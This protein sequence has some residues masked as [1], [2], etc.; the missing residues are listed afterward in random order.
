MKK[1]VFAGILCFLVSLSFGQKKAVSAARNEIKG[2]PPNIAEARVIIK[3]ALSNPET[4]KDAETWYVAGLIENKQVDVEN[5]LEI[6]GKQ[7]NEEVMYNALEKIIPYFLKA[8]ELDQQPDAKGK[9]KPRFLKDIRSIIRA[10]RLFYINAG[11]FAYNKG[12][13]QKA[14]EHFKHFT[15]IPK[16]ELFKEEKWEIAPGDT[17]VLQIKCYS[18]MAASRIPDSKAAIAAY[19]GIINDGYTEN[20][21]FPEPE[22]FQYLS[23]EYIQIGDS[24]AYKKL[25]DQ[26]FVKF[27]GDDFFISSLINYYI[28]SGN[29]QEAVTYLLKGIEKNPQSAQFYALLGQL[30]YEDQKSEEAIAYL[31]KALEIEPDNVAFLSE[32]GRIYFNLGV[33]K[34]RTADDTAD[35][36]KSRELTKESLEFYRLSLPFFDKVFGLDAT[37]RDAIFA[38]RNIYYSLEMWPQYEKMDAIFS[39][40][41]DK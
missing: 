14:Y 3:E 15:D 2:N 18:G 9:V 20:S 35:V 29:P 34:R 16:M 31:K 36:V 33:E 11:V 37:N 32:L 8:A 1:F 22:I 12:N 25:L 23:R 5:T 17:T 27:P 10:N 24:A 28:E 39:S 13:F 21:L 40:I 4:A 41:N 38:L 30:K 7:P 6:L 19:E 26:G